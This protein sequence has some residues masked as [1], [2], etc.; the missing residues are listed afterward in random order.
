MTLRKN[1]T[2]VLILN[3]KLGALAIMRSLGTLGIPLYGVDADPRSAG[4]TSRYCRGKFIKAYEEES[5]PDYLDYVL[6]IGKQLGQKTISHTYLRRAVG[7]R[8]GIC[9]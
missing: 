8:V 1:N 6:R 3:C 4:L 2:P 7:L 5:A 9:G